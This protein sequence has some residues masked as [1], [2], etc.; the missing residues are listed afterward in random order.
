MILFNVIVLHPDDSCIWYKI[1][2]QVFIKYYG[3]LSEYDQLILNKYATLLLA[4][5]A[6]I[7]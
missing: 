7:S 3:I 1:Y 5:S 6:I 4:P 2:F